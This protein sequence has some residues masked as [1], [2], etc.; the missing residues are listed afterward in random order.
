MH[1]TTIVALS[2]LSLALSS[3]SAFADETAKPAAKKGNVIVV[4]GVDVKGR[5]PW[6]CMVDVARV[7]QRAP[8][9]E[10]RKPLVDIA[11]AADRDPF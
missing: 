10:L 1:R 9:P 7:V 11:A 4:P 3:A 6:G 8:L 5:A 2:V